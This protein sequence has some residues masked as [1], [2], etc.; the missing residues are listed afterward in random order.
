MKRHREE[1]L[2]G[3]NLLDLRPDRSYQWEPNCGRMEVSEAKRLRD[4]EQVNAR[5]TLL[6]AA[7]KLEKAALKE[8]VEGK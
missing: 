6:L 2:K 5:L 8:L 1:D 3:K 7:A 4:L